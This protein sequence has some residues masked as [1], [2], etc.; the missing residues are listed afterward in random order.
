[1]SDPRDTDSLRPRLRHVRWL[2][3]PPDAGKTTVTTCSRDRLL[4]EHV[5]RE[6]ER[7]GLPL[8]EVDGTRSV[9]ETADLLAARFGLGSGDA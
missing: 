1:L 7:R 5:R 3:G 6:A 9:V 8:V 4:G 2:G